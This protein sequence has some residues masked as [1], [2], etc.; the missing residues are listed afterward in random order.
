MRERSFLEAALTDGLMLTDHRVQFMPAERDDHFESLI[1][2]VWHLLEAR[3]IAIGAPWQT[4]PEDRRQEIMRGIGSISGMIPMLCFT[5]VPQGRDI[6]YQHLSFGGYGLVIQRQW[7]ESNGADR[8]LYV[9]DNSPVS[10]HINRILA[11]L[12]ISNLFVDATTGLVV[13]NNRCSRAVLDL[14]AY[15]ETRDNLAEFEWRIAGRHGFFGGVRDSGMR[16]P[17][18]LD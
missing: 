2:E 12:K 6:T 18:G 16:I 9:G 1:Y 17:I 3:L 14:I 8:V 11:S 7:L 4:L 15:I 5:E 13:F 10:R